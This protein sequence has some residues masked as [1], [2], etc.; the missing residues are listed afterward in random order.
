MTINERNIFLVDAAGAALSVVLLGAI[1]PALNRFIG[2]PLETLYLLAAL[3]LVF[4]IYDLVVY[5]FA[6]LSRPVWLRL[7]MAA[8]LGYCMLTIA[9]MVVHSDQLKPLGFAYFI[10][11]QPVLVALVGLQYKVG[12]RTEST[13]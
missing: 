2:M 6:D 8:N 4:G 11:E 12:R 9:L 10:A 7:I 13:G 3:P 1:V 5:N